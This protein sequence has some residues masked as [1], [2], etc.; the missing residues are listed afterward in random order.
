MIP[1]VIS[2][3][4][5][6]SMIPLLN[7]LQNKWKLSKLVALSVTLLAFSS[8]SFIF[9]LLFISSIQ[10]F[11]DGVSI[12]RDR[13]LELTQTLFQLAEKLKIPV[14]ATFAENI[15]REL[16][17]FLLAK[18]VTGY[19]LTLIG[20]GTVIFIFTAFMIMSKPKH[21]QRNTLIFDIRKKTG[22]YISIK[23]LTST[24]IAIFTWLLLKTFQIELALV[25][26]LLA[27]IFNF[28]PS[29]GAF[30]AVGLPLPIIY[31]QY[32]FGIE[33]YVILGLTLSI[34]FITGNFIEAKVLGDALELHPIS[35]L[36]SLLFWGII[37]GFPG[38]FL[39]VPM[40]VVL[41][42]ILGQNSFTQPFSK[43]LEGKI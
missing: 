28:I 19:A 14:D 10:R 37:W 34:Q 4:T 41:K 29:L 5:Y 11:I 18:N 12:Y 9:V 33:F 1:F 8:V 26:S 2:V 13:V 15:I 6:F 39:A 21:V 17:I 16:P 31:L 24:G 38:M 30:L 22:R 3:F 7:W 20:Y 35:I 27:F 36:F 25:F 43:V 32:G 40:T 23:F 42:I